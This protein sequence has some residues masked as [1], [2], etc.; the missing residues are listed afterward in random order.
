MKTIRPKSSRL[1]NEEWF[2]YHT[3]LRE[4]IQR[5]GAEALGVAR[6][7]IRY[8][9]LLAEAD[10]A[11]E[12]ARKSELTSDLVA[13]D[14]ARVNLFRSLRDAIQAYQNFPDKNKEKA[15]QKLLDII[16]LYS[17]GIFLGSQANQTASIDN[18]I[19]DLTGTRG[20][21][22]VSAQVAILGIQPWVE[23]LRESNAAYVDILDARQDEIAK[24][25]A[26]GLLVKLRALTDHHYTCMMNIIDATLLAIEDRLPTAKP[27]NDTQ[28]VHF[29]QVFNAS[30]AYYKV[31]LEQRKTKRGT[32]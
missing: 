27:E 20:G 30:A 2:R 1:N 3:M 18:L 7:F 29:A 16:E 15:A 14:E 22:D 12:Q 6:L 4:L 9:E 17:K 28:V 23:A 21:N 19:Q 10:A 5:H 26:K 25:P 24:R 11:L 13:E 31:L 8:L 32:S